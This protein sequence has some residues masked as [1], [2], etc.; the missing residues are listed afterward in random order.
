MNDI[1]T[2]RFTSLV[3]DI[4]TYLMASGAHCG[5]I[6]TN[7]K[8]MAD[9]WNFEIN[10]HPSFKGLLVSIKKK[11]NPEDYVT[12]YQ[13]SPPH[14]VQLSALTEVSRLSWQVVADKLTIDETEKRFKL[15]KEQSGYNI[16]I[17]SLA[18]AMACAG[19]C[20]FSLGDIYNATVAFVAA[21][22][23]SI[24][25]FK[26]AA[27]KFN[28]M[29]SIAIAAFITTLITGLGSIYTIGEQPQAAMATAVLYLI[30]GVPLINC[31]I[32]LIEG[33]LSSA[34]NRALFA[35]FTL[36]CIAAGMTLSITLMGISNF[37]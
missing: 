8:R 9:K 20:I 24:A 34:M 17:V 33:Y 15:I 35:G 1:S 7:I 23:G 30:P 29:I 26:V 12:L 36:L 5:R 14:H 32:D 37:N 4:G 6:N 3:L 31:V 2:K 13:A 19:L 18:V 10:M 28:P 25:R 11:D 16:W 22:I 27:M 21:F